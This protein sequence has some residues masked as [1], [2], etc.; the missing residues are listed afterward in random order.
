MAKSKATQEKQD[1]PIEV[2]FKFPPEI[3]Q[4]VKKRQRFISASKDF[5]ATMEDAVI[6]II[7]D[8]KH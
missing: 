5:D 7:R 2:R 1:K 8:A 3:H 4:K 6:D